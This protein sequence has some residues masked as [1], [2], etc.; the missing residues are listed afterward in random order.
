MTGIVHG[1]YYLWVPVGYPSSQ[2]LISISS[3]V[4]VLGAESGVTALLVSKNNIYVLHCKKPNFVP[5]R[6]TSIYSQTWLIQTYW[7][8]G[9]FC[10]D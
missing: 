2:V 10:S 4:W 8:K 3:I 9:S 7:S 6:Y 5:K 1:Y